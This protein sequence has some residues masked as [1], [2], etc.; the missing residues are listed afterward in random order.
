M[1]GE[2]LRQGRAQI[3]IYRLRL[4]ADIERQPEF[5]HVCTVIFLNEV[6]SKNARMQHVRKGWDINLGRLNTTKNDRRL[7][8]RTI[9]MSRPVRSYANMSCCVRSRNCG[10]QPALWLQ[11]AWK[12]EERIK[13]TDGKLLWKEVV[14]EY[15]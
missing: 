15:L 12:L 6:P 8:K 1:T 14:M 13:L 10:L 7:T 11:M 9:T 3:N 5:A 2:G 4:A